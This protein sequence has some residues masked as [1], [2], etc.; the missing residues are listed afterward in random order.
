[1]SRRNPTGKHY[2]KSALRYIGES[3]TAAE[4]EARLN[5]A[6][7]SYGNA[8]SGTVRKWRRAVER[9]REAQEGRLR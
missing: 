9:I 1:M 6:L 3:R 7:A 8:S 5:G 4:A 2:G